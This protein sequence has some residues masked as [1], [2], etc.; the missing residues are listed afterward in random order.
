MEPKNKPAKNE[1]EDTAETILE[2]TF[3]RFARSTAKRPARKASFCAYRKG[4]L[5]HG[6]KA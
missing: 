5:S 4:K 3:G 1:V 2:E 6:S